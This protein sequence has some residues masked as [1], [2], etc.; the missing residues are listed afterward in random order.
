MFPAV[1]NH[2]IIRNNVS[3][4][5]SQFFFAYCDVTVE[6]A[7][8]TTGDHFYPISIDH[9]L[10]E[11]HTISHV[12]LLVKAASD[13][14]F[15]LPKHNCSIVACNNGHKSLHKSSEPLRTQHITALF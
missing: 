14:M 2:R 7:P 8:P 10:S 1:F 9:A 5:A 15:Q 6:Q 12:Y 3:K 13:I 4:P 11:P